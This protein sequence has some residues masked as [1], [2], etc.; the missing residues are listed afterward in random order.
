MIDALG[1]VLRL[2]GGFFPP[3]LSA[4]YLRALLQ[5]IAETIGMAAAGM[6]VAF[7]L[8]VPLAVAIATR[9]PG[10][11]LIVAVLSSL[12]AIPDLT[13]AILAVVV[14]GLGPAAGIAALAVFY[15]AMVGRV[16]GDLFVAA[17]AA[18]LEAL[19][20]TGASRVA[21]AA[22]GLI[23][24]TQADLLTFGTY[25][26]ECA[27]R[28]SIIVGAVGGGGIGAELVGALST[29]DFHRTL[30]IIIV[31]VALVAGVDSFGM[32]A[33]R[34]PRTV[35]VLLPVGL[36]ALWLDRPQIFAF[37][38]ALHTFAGMFP[39][40]L[41]AE[42]IVALPLLIAQTLAIAMGGTL[43]G[44]VLAFPVSLI[45]ARRLAPFALVVAVRRVLDVARAIPE[46]VF[47]LILVVSVGI[48]P[49][50]GA[51]ALGLHSAGVLGKLYA[52][53]F[54][55]VPVAPI[56]SLAATGARPLPIVAFGFLPLALGPLVVHTLFRLEWNV[57]AATVVGLIGAGG[58]GQALFQAQQ[59]FFYRQ[60]FAYVLVTWALVALSDWLGER[61]RIRLGW[62]FVA[63]G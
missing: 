16:F 35:L 44:A 25:A 30:T 3:D 46:L 57:R 40:Q 41:R 29:L 60:M 39:P 34:A 12:R 31:L 42:Q 48:G 19:R 8:G 21:I 59:L 33:R 11:R 22:F 53:S 27:M 26:F 7:A 23:P 54:E 50:A 38:H 5:P 52:E 4:H 62:H 17:D 9:A 56:A 51:I 63:A 36:I 32:L 14:L 6:L 37:V 45:A 1:N 43:L 15:T 13:L 58:V 49:L 47:G 28:A 10:H 24:L 18:P 61:L 20:A 2:V 55:N